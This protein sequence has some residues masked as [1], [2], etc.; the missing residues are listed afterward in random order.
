MSAD[1]LRHGTQCVGYMT[2]TVLHRFGLRDVYLFEREAISIWRGMNSV[3]RNVCVLLQT[4]SEG[5]EE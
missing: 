1:S 5:Y 3:I 2:C 4:N